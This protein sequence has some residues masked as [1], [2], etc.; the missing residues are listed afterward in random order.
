M[1][2][3]FLPLNF[4]TCA[5]T[6]CLVYLRV[7]CLSPRLGGL[8]LE[9]EGFWEVLE[10]NLHRGFVTLTVVLEVAALSCVFCAADEVVLTFKKHFVLSSSQPAPLHPPVETVKD[11]E[12]NV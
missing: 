8:S 7:S 11:A 4:H 9:L 6:D 2:F 3:C 1:L 5:S 12:P 10:G